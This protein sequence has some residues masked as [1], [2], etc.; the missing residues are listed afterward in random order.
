NILWNFHRGR[1]F[2][3][4]HA[5]TGQFRFQL[6]VAFA[7]GRQRIMF[8]G[9]KQFIPD[10]VQNR[11]HVS[12]AAGDSHYRVLLGHDDA[13]LSEGA[14]ASVGAMTRPPEL[15]AVSLIPVTVGVAAIGSL[16]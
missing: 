12:D 5:E 8:H 16:P 9:R 2:L 3:D 15:V 13:E 1:S 14:V 10:E 4:R 6:S 11:L 7:V